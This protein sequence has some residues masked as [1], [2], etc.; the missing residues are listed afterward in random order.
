MEIAE[1][2][3]YS[4]NIALGMHFYTGSTVAAESLLGVKFRITDEELQSPYV[5]VAE[6]GDLTLYENKAALPLA[7]IADEGITDISGEPDDLFEYQ[8]EIYGCIVGID[9]PTT[10]G[11]DTSAATQD[12]EMPDAASD[13][14]VGDDILT[15]DMNQGSGG[16]IPLSTASLT[17]VNEVNCTG[18]SDGTYSVTDTSQVG[19][20]DYALNASGENYYISTDNMRD[21]IVFVIADGA[22]LEWGDQESTT[23]KLGYFTSENEVIV[24]VAFVGDEPYDTGALELYAE[25]SSALIAGAD[26]AAR[27][28]ISRISE[29]SSHLQ[30]S[31]TNSTDTLQYVVLTIPYDAGWS[32]K[33]D[34]VETG[35]TEVISHFIAVPLEPGTHDIEISFTP[36]YLVAG[37]IVSLV[38]LAIVIFFYKLIARSSKKL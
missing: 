5:A 4:S 17:V 6:S 24:R 12:I 34:G 29:S 31:C 8:N 7:F 20:V 9:N 32:T 3:G 37:I 36:P 14:V 11:V 21:P 28:L 30:Y 25:D 23:K 27:Q 13:T 18:N 38:C 35:I 22:E 2:F 15:T 10:C 33:V 1:N 19:I 26:V 16:C